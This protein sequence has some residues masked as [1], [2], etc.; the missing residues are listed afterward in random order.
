MPNFVKRASNSRHSRPEHANVGS[1]PNVSRLRPPKATM[2]LSG[3]RIDG[4]YDHFWVDFCL[5]DGE[6]R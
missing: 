5:H 2:P 6:V 1:R 3:S 4:A